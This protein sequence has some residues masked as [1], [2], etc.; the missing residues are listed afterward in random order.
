MARSA[1]PVLADL[2][3]LRAPERLARLLRAAGKPVGRVVQMDAEPMPSGYSR[4]VLTRLT[5][6][7]EPP[8]ASASW[9]TSLI[10]KDIAP[11]HGWLGAASAD[12]RIRE[13]QLWRSGLLA[14]LPRTAATGV[15]A[16]AYEG[17]GD[18]P[19]AGA[20]LLT[21]L[22]TRLLRRPLVAP[23]PRAS[24]LPRLL[25]TLAQMHA[26]F[27]NAPALWRPDVGLVPTGAALLFVA[28]STVAARLAE[29]DQDAYLAG[30]PAGWEA[31][32]AAA[33]PWAAAKLRGVL[34]EPAP[35][36]RE[37]ERLPVTLVH[38]D[39]W[40]P[41][42]GDLPTRLLRSGARVGRRILLLDWALATAG[43]C[44]YDV[45]WLCGTWHALDP[46]RT[47]AVYRAR[48]RR[49]LERRGRRLDTADWCALADAGYLRTAL[50]C[51]EAFGR[52]VLQ[53]PAGA[54]RRRAER[55]AGWWAARAASAARRL[56][57][58]GAGRHEL[59]AL[60]P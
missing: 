59:P 2:P 30:I 37:I 44:T 11:L 24:W 20:L 45:L 50:V 41:N 21:D 54:P 57:A 3:E 12:A 17:N 16:A 4:S 5:L 32:V 49:H 26:T 28:P 34:A 1:V 29:G 48:L 33:P 47:M 51:G 6:R 56:R 19:R 7:I 40:G 35:Y 14:G 31:F 58:G 27:W 10:V 8:G 25:D 9:R 13:V 39:V 42:L 38:G 53:A 23:H 15:L 18:A 36:V 52:A 22:R 46:Q 43:P 60:K 55:R